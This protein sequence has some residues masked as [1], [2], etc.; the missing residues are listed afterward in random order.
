MIVTV[1]PNPALDL[2]WRAA[3]VEP[4]GSHRV[5][6][7]LVRAGGKGLNVARVAHAQGE[8]VL[9]ITTAGGAVGAE[10]ARELRESGVPH[11]L[12]PVAAATRRSA[13]IVD[14]S[15]GDTMI[16]NERGENPA[17][18]EWDALVGAVEDAAA[19]AR[20]LVVSGSLPSGADP[21][22]VSRLAAVGARNGVP[23]VVD[24]SGP[25]LLA[26]ADAGAALLKPN[27]AELADATGLDDP[28]AGARLLVERGARR[29]LCSLGADGML[30]VTAAP[31]VLRARLPEPLAGNPTGAGDA[32]VA[33]AAVL[34]RADPEVADERLLVAAASWSAAAVLAPGAGE[35]SP[36]HPELAARLLL[37]RPARL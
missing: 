15:L 12:V 22:V 25:G 14:E 21:G 1:T 34:L 36:R 27:R 33:A 6:A 37:D 29:V 20:V 4:G 17:R 18:A 24:V 19:S 8:P 13:A 2:T 5:D 35:I 23:L 32:A 9:A 16:F 30:L 11:R 10:F 31:T 3:H 26:A 7:A 28:L